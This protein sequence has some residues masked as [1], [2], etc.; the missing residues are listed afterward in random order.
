MKKLLHIIAAALFLIAGGTATAQDSGPAYGTQ[1]ENRGFENWNS[2]FSGEPYH[3]HGS[4]ASATGGYTNYLPDNPIS[5]DSHVRPGSS[6]NNTKSVKTT[7]KKVTVFIFSAMANGEITNGRMKADGM[8]ATST[9]NCN[10]TDTGNSLC[11]T[12]LQNGDLPDSITM[13]IH[14]YTKNSGVEGKMYSALHSNT[15]FEYRA[16]ASIS[17][18]AALYKAAFQKFTR[19]TSSTSDYSAN[20][21]KRISVPYGQNAEGSSS[22]AT[23]SCS[24]EN[25]KYVLMVITTN[26]TGGEGSDGDF[27]NVDD[28]LLIY[29]PT[30]TT[31]DLAKSEYNVGEQMEIPFLIT[32]T[33]SPE[34]LNKAAN[35]VIAERSDANGSFDN[36]VE[37]GRVTTNE[38]GSIFVTLP[39]NITTSSNYRIRVRSTNYPMTAAPTNYIRINGKSTVYATV[40]PFNSGSINLIDGTNTPEYSAGEFFDGSTINIIA[41]A[42]TGYVFSNWT[43]NDT[44]VSTDASYSFV[45]NGDRNLVANFIAAPS[46]EIT[47][48]ANPTNGGNVSGA[49][50]YYQGTQCTLTATPADGYTFANWTKNG[51]VVS[52]EA[53]Y[54]FTVTEAGSYVANFTLN[55]YEITATA[56][57]TEGGTVSGAGTYNHGA[58]C[59]LTAT[60]STGYTFANWTK[61]GDV[62]SENATYTFNVTE[63]GSYVANFTINSY[64]ITAIANPTEGGTISG[65]G[66]YDY[67]QSCTLTATANQGYIFK[68]WTKNDIIVSVE[69]SIT[70]NVTDNATY[71]ANF[72][73]Q[74]T[75]TV[76]ANPEEGGTVSGNGTYEDGT[77]VT[78]IATANEGYEFVNWTKEGDAE[79]TEEASSFTVT[80]SENATYTAN[81]AVTYKIT[82]KATEGGTATGGGNYIAGATATLIATP[83]EGYVFTS[84]TLNGEI[85]STDTIYDI[86]VTGAA[87]YMANFDLATYEISVDVNPAET[88]TA[89]GSG[90]YEHGTQVTLNA[91][92][93]TGYHFVNWTMDGEE[94]STDASYTFNAT[95]SA[96]YVA[97]FEINEYEIIVE[98]NPAEAGTVEGAG[99]YEHGSTATLTA[100]ADDD[101]LF[102]N[103]TL[104]GEEV[105]TDATYSFEVTAEGTYVANFATKQEIIVT[106]NDTEAGSVNGGGIVAYGQEITIT[107][108]PNEGFT[109]VNWTVDGVEVSTDA[110]YT[111]T[112]TGN[113]TYTANFEVSQYTITVVANPTE[114][115]VV[116]GEGIYSHGSTV[117]LT[118]TP[119]EHYEFINWAKDGAF[120]SDEAE[121]SFTA[122]ESATFSAT[123]TEE[124]APTEYT[125]T[126]EAA[127]GG[128]I[129]PEGDVT[130]PVGTNQTFTITP[131]EHKQIQS[132]YVDGENMGVVSEYTF[133]NV[134][135]NHNITAYF[136][137][138][139]YQVTTSVNIEGSGTVSEGG[140]YWYNTTITLT[141]EANDGYEFVN[142][143]DAEGTVVSETESFD[144]TVTEDV[145]YIANFIAIYDIDVLVNIEDGGTVDGGG[146]YREGETAELTAYANEGYIFLNWTNGDEVITNNPYSFTVT[147]SATYTANFIARYRINVSGT[148]G[149]TAAGGGYFNEGETVTLT[150]NANDGYVFTGWTKNDDEDIVSTDNPYIFDASENASYTAH[151][152]AQYTITVEAGEGGT[153]EPDGEQTYNAGDIVTLTAYPDED[154]LFNNWTKNGNI[155]STNAEYTF[156]ASESATYVANFI[157]KSSIEFTI[158]AMAG[159]HGTITPQ[160]E[161]IVTYGQDFTFTITP[162]AE[163][164]ISALLVDGV[165]VDLRGEVV[166]YT[167]YDV[168]E[169][170]SIEAIF[171][172]DGI[173]TEMTEAQID[174]YPNPASR[175]VNIKGDDLREVRIY[176]ISGV[177]VKHEYTNG[178]NTV[179][180]N[181]S[182][183]AVGIYTVQCI[184]AEKVTTR[185]FIKK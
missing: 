21:W 56:N 173:E 185:N 133:Y 57:P 127:L 88:G 8:S 43:E 178:A 137:D 4:K 81:F 131:D 124:A 125:I 107:A 100:T 110:E 104:D 168:R 119:N 142:W 113:A 71:T 177:L 89:T 11:N 80:V 23:G 78:L 39:D 84:W 182:D 46:F 140:I 112:V 114:G 94:V 41:T 82:V 16:N 26:K 116:T 117:T 146:I 44:P 73:G 3:W 6:S 165:E 40:S 37:L 170:H 54:T 93:S 156:T 121:I 70:F 15:N 92:A 109:F 12:P 148:Q 14:F 147:E 143:T 64:E 28:V 48:S 30:L 162:D 99:T 1:F 111:F 76:V 160:G 103:W 86:T 25:A 13:W 141:A 128:S 105:S 19:T 138:A 108:T 31:G 9:D 183:L 20:T 171:E 77:S 67:G 18:T 159:D 120:Y 179:Q 42:N 161:V 47:A 69:S 38:S 49:G 136:D 126:A 22:P 149:G 83:S 7:A 96:T 85:V 66:T 98:A 102:V 55:S 130:V 172:F 27:L 17:S 87:T 132:V 2:T 10:Y 169:S 33:M 35:E 5:S 63:A 144:L 180:V 90:I 106:I 50:S 118:A 164:E 53:S 134:Q 181:V 184:G 91:T 163:Y 176:N 135:D 65:A 97:N 115:G 101:H 68:N 145:N 175:F 74:H 139:Q 24:A 157:A 153:V 34:N 36:A 122:T 79:W 59:T 52:E 158:T 32:G 152:A 58:S 151:F 150:A 61:N 166:E 155:V 29:N 95:G 62:V 167:F 174:L 45:L 154:H 129:D 72:V 60:E 51:D 75:L 123:F